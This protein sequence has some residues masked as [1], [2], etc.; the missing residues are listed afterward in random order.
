M[1]AFD[2]GNDDSCAVK[3]IESQHGPCDPLDGAMILFDDNVHIFRLPHRDGN[4]AVGLDDD[5]RRLVG[6][7][8]VDDD[9]LGHVV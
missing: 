4:A 6:T 3:G 7:V 2:V 9:F 5:Y 8:L 1:H